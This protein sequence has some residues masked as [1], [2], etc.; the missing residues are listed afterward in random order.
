MKASVSKW[1]ALGSYTYVVALTS[2]ESFS[3]KSFAII[4]QIY[5]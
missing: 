3:K 2:Q 5:I 1:Y 4:D